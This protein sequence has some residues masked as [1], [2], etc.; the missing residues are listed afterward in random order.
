MDV[1]QL[2]PGVVLLLP[3]L[4]G[5]SGCERRSC[6]TERRP[7]DQRNKGVAAAG[8]GGAALTFSRVVQ[9]EALK[10]LVL[11]GDLLRGV[12]RQDVLV[13]HVIQTWS[14]E[15]DV[16]EAE[17]RTPTGEGVAAHLVWR[18]GLG[19]RR[20]WPGTSPLRSG[21]AETEQQASR[22]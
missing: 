21:S 9:E 6:G 12:V 13:A 11:D 4:Q 8:R 20:G 14:T 2:Q 17:G 1:R 22:H 16:S 18:R 5:V 10:E 15:K 3:R 19:C 7:G